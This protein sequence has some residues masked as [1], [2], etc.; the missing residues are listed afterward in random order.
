MKRKC[1]NSQT[2]LLSASGRFWLELKINVWRMVAIFLAF[3]I[4]PET[5][6]FAQATGK[7]RQTEITLQSALP[8]PKAKFPG[9]PENDMLRK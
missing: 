4:L 6:L 5:S 8:S 7:N 2:I 1:H 9:N 3:L